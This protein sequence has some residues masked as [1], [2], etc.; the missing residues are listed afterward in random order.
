MR[1]KKIEKTHAKEKRSYAQN[2]IYV[3]QQFIYVHKIAGISIL[4]GK[5]TSAAI[6][7]FNL[8]KTTIIKNPNYKSCVFYILCI[9]FT[10]GY[11]TGQKFSTSSENLSL[12]NH[13]TLF[14]SDRVVN[15]IKHNQAPQN[16]TKK[17][18]QMIHQNDQTSITPNERPF[19]IP[20][21]VWKLVWKVKL[22][23]KILNFIWKLLHDSLPI[24]SIL[25][26][27]GIAA[28]TRCLLCD[29]SDE[30]INHLFL[31]C[32]FARAI[33]HGSILG[34]RTSDLTNVSVKQWIASFFTPTY[35]L[36]QC[37]MMFLQS[38]FTILWTLWNHRNMILHQGKT[39]NPMEVV[40][41]SQSLICRYQDAFKDSQIQ[42]RKPNQ[43]N[44][45]RIPN[46][47]WQ[48]IIKV[49]AYKNRRSRKSGYAY[50]A[51]SM[52]GRVL[53]TGGVNKGRK[54]P[55]LVLQEAVGEA[56]IKAKE[57]VFNKLIIL[58]NSRRLE[59][60]CNGSKSPTWQEHTFIA[61]LNQ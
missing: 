61:D 30:T 29:D 2:N 45:Q 57:L 37:K 9:G 33:W 36:E 46:H 20:Q 6:Q 16:P 44:R 60:I 31:N 14:G 18:Y 55:Y 22:P 12:K 1:N 34:V 8:S 51:K 15:R 7:C 17:A 25:N 23:T 58:S 13:A 38:C 43:Q 49:A 4:S 19:G 50:E 47:E 24:F 11:K 21:Y 3:I 54:P 52:E 39:P 48:I 53:F 35:P 40:L 42:V 26:S 32:P 27:R 41:T 10:I 59:Q 5:N 28:P 56:I